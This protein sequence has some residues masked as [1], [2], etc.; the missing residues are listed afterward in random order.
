MLCN[1]YVATTALRA[2]FLSFCCS[3]VYFI[4]VVPVYFFRLMVLEDDSCHYMSHC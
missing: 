1:N 4:I 3:I 2:H